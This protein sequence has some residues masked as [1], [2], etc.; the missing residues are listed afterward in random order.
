MWIT[1]VQP[2]C[3]WPMRRARLALR[4]M[5]HTARIISPLFQIRAPWSFSDPLKEALVH[6]D[7]P[8]APWLQLTLHW[9]PHLLTKVGGVFSFHKVCC[10]SVQPSVAG[11]SF[12]LILIFSCTAFVFFFFTVNFLDVI[13]YLSKAVSSI[14]YWSLN[15]LQQCEGPWVI[16]YI[17]TA[18]LGLNKKASCSS[19]HQSC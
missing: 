19:G 18:R 2:H 4:S 17:V 11:V 7:Q 16:Q 15:L 5:R 6:S 10:E 13:D 1:A 9:K 3:E 14:H 12:S 8:E